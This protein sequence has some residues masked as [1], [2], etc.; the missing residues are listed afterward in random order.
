MRH[1]NQFRPKGDPNAP[2]YSPQRDVA[3]IFTPML[4]EVFRGLDAEN[5]TPFFKAWFEREGITQ[6]QL[7]ES[8]AVFMEAHRLFIRDREVNSP[9]DAFV[10]AG[11]GN[12]PDAVKYALF[13]RLGEVISGGFFVALRDV[14]MQ[15]QHSNLQDDMASMIA[16]GRALS[17]RMSGAM[18]F[19]EEGAAERW[20]ADSE[21][22]RRV[23]KQ[24]QEA[25]AEAETQQRLDRS[26]AQLWERRFQELA[27]QVDP[28]VQAKC[29]GW[30]VRIFRTIRVAWLVYW[31]R[32]L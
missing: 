24:L 4:R 17:K 23:V 16:A 3:N 14:T 25:A 21:E 18:G 20:Q 26:T 2:M 19:Y 22:S 30:F 32:L 6:E 27:R 12:L 13:C 29:S 11:A 9:A 7:G 31:K 1:V 5:W 15:G 28:I 8:V 10:K